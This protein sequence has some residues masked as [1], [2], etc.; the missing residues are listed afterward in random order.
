MFP[1]RSE[2]NVFNEVKNKRYSSFSDFFEALFPW[3]YKDLQIT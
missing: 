3:S 1:Y 2:K